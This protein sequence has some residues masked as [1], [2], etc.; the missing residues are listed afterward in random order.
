MVW[1]SVRRKPIVKEDGDDEYGALLLIWQHQYE[2]IFDIRWVVDIDACHIAPVFHRIFYEHQRWTR[3]ITTP[4]P[5]RIKES[6]FYPNLCGLL[7]KETLII[8]VNLY[9]K[10]E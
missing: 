1:N 5:A 3:S 8:C 7:G 6:K 9:V 4:K 10:W 2:G